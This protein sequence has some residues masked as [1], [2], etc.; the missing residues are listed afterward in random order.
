MITLYINGSEY[1]VEAPND[2]PLLWVLR[3]D[4]R[5]TGTK[6]GC[7]AALCGACTV[8]IAGNPARACVVPV[9]AAV[10]RSITTVEGVGATPI[11]RKVQQVWAELNVP[12]CG[13]CQS[14]QIMAAVAL[15]ER[16]PRPNDA[17][18]DQAMSGNICRCGMY[19]R[20]RQALH[21]LASEQ[22]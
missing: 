17:E 20:I 3:D 15:L 4:L 8:Y 13:Y 1:Q 5:M 10:G 14:G 2:K 21:R 19:P 18:I 12:Q 11:G 16:N 6:Y 22:S 9:G 7:G